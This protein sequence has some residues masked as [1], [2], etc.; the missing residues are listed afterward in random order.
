MGRRIDRRRVQHSEGVR[1]L[2]L[3]EHSVFDPAQSQVFDCLFT[4]ENPALRGDATAKLA[5][6]RGLSSSDAA[7]G[8]DSDRSAT[9]AEIVAMLSALRHHEIVILAAINQLIHQHK[10]LCWCDSAVQLPNLSSAPTARLHLAAAGE[11]YLAHAI[12]NAEYVFECSRHCPNLNSQMAS[13]DLPVDAF[14]RQLRIALDRLNEAEVR[15]VDAAIGNAERGLYLR[16]LGR[17][18]VSDAMA[19]EI[20]RQALN[21]IDARIRNLGNA[22]ASAQSEIERLKAEHSEWHL[23]TS[24]RI[25]TRSRK[26]ELLLE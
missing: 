10:R 17:G 22:G 18:L 11:W 2:M 26:A 8:T 3:G 21:R 25:G 23:Y 20:R 16:R 15:D 13:G 1:A 4:T 7:L 19:Q 5:I 14:S 24:L 12:Y 6:L 9:I